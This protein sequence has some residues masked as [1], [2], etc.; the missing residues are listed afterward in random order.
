LL[1]VLLAFTIAA[2]LVAIERPSPI[3][4]ILAWPLRCPP[5][6]LA[7]AGAGQETKPRRRHRK[8]CH[9]MSRH[10]APRVTASRHDRNFLRKNGPVWGIRSQ[11]VIGSSPIVGSNAI[12]N[13]HRS[14]HS[15]QFASRHSVANQ[16]RKSAR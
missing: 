2:V 7:T 8:P 13:F 5:L 10:G 9:A 14:P 15:R 6:A 11:Q 3:A 12:N 1:N 16:Q 4:S